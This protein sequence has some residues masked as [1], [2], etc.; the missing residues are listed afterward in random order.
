[1]FKTT[2]L[3]FCFFK[4]VV[5][6]VTVNI[7]NAVTSPIRRLESCVSPHRIRKYPKFMFINIA[8]TKQ[9]SAHNWHTIH[10]KKSSK[11][12]HFWLF[13]DRFSTDFRVFF[14]FFR[15]IHHNFVSFGVSIT[16]E[17]SKIIWWVHWLHFWGFRGPPLSFRVFTRVLTRVK[18]NKIAFLSVFWKLPYFSVEGAHPEFA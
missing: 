10:K 12:R 18:N 17:E 16:N 14:D 1:M 9:V 4:E 7:R 6:I 15:G 3:F 5:C 2:V 11:K 8:H 13:F